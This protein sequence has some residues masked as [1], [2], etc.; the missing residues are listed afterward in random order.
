MQEI[1]VHATV[2]RSTK[3]PAQSRAGHHKRLAVPWREICGLLEAIEGEQTLRGFFQRTLERLDALVPY[4]FGLAIL[5]GADQPHK[6]PIV[7]SRSAPR[8]LIDRYSRHYILVDPERPVVSTVGDEM[9]RWSPPGHAVFVTD[10][11][12]PRNDISI[13]VGQKEAG[14]QGFVISL[15][16]QRKSAF[17]LLEKKI[18]EAL[19]PHLHNFF[20]A[21]T[22]PTHQHQLRLLSAAASAGLSRREKE[23][24]LLL[25]DRLTIAE[26]AQRLF[27]SRHTAAKHI[28]HIY[29]KLLVSGR[30]GACQPGD[31]KG[32]EA[33]GNAGGL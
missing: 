18:L 23:I 14:S 31:H 9:L 1:S 19:F 10:F 8:E 16:R 22:D 20:R 7:I 5:S 33:A 30:R 27:I 21:L 32:A 2:G 28:E 11:L 24:Y 17:S 26:I 3:S 15:H 13:S 25:C 29:D 4:D 6:Q 12:A